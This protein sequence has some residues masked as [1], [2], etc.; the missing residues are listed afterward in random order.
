M[1]KRFY[2]SKKIK[3]A[4]LL[5]SFAAVISMGSCKSAVSE[6]KDA[7]KDVFA[8]SQVSE[9]SS[10][11]SS[12]EGSSRTSKASPASAP[13]VSFDLT[14]IP[15][16]SGIPYVEIN[17]NIPYFE[18]SDHSTEAFEYYAELDSLGRCGV[19][20]ANVC[21]E[22][23]PTEKRGDISKVKPTGWYSIKY[24]MVDGQSL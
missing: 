14:N 9:T 13:A 20:Y 16:Y 12:S 24:D 11:K 3:A 23:M 2:L 1:R 15:E 6:I 22:T 19:A 8:S 5:L 7:I 17:N 4:A 18:E 21:K 10:G